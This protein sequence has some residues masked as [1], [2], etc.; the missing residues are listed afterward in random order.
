PAP[1]DYRLMVAPSGGDYWGFAHC[2]NWRGS[3]SVRRQPATVWGSAQPTMRTVL[4]AR[5]HRRRATSAAE[6]C[7]VAHEGNPQAWDQSLSKCKAASNL[8]HRLLWPIDGKF[9]RADETQRGYAHEGA[10]EQDRSHTDTRYRG[11]FHAG[12]DADGLDQAP[13]RICLQGSD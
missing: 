9:L 1:R 10:P 4:P 12:T 11:P 5:G 8:P 7:Q 2:Q 6:N 3:L 13:E